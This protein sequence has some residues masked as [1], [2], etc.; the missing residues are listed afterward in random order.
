MVFTSSAASASP[1]CRAG[2]DRQGNGDEAR[3]PLGVD[4]AAEQTRAEVETADPIVHHQL[5][6]IAEHDGAVAQPLVGDV[7]L[8]LCDSPRPEILER[9]RLVRGEG[10]PGEVGEPEPG[11]PVAQHT[12]WDRDDITGVDHP[13]AAERAPLHHADGEVV[14][15]SSAPVHVELVVH[16]RTA[17]G[18]LPP[19]QV[20]PLF[21]HEHFE[22]GLGEC[23][24]RS[25]S[26]AARPD[27]TDVDG[28]GQRRRLLRQRDDGHRVTSSPRSTGP[29]TSRAYDGPR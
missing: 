28:A 15:R 22:A 20:G 21:Q 7:D 26:A 14:G 1:E 13:A 19:G 12:V 9:Q 3:V 18:E 5:A 29:S 27:D 16:L 24:R 11:L 25:A 23:A 2:S 10:L 4:R 8:F 17:L 6:P